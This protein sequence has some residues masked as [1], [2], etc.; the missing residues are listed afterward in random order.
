MNLRTLALA[1]ALVASPLSAQQW[2][3]FYTP[4]SPS[5]RCQPC[6][7]E[8]QR[9]I[10]AKGSDSAENVQDAIELNEER[11]LNAQTDEERETYKSVIELVKRDVID[12]TVFADVDAKA[13]RV[14]HDRPYIF[15][16]LIDEFKDNLSSRLYVDEEGLICNITIPVEGV[17]NVGISYAE[18]EHSRLLH[19]RVDGM[20]DEEYFT[21]Q[22]YDDGAMNILSDAYVGIGETSEDARSKF[23]ANLKS[24]NRDLSF[25]N[26]ELFNKVLAALDERYT[27][28]RV[29]EQEELKQL[30]IAERQL[31]RFSGMATMTSR[32][33]AAAVMGSLADVI[34]ESIPAI[35]S[36]NEDPL[37]LH[38]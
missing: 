7:Q 35:Q 13:K 10:F 14:L 37:G 38:R 8:N 27:A 5:R 2:S 22:F 33:D 18:R 26:T 31:N 12:D 17:E 4:P 25:E 20:R 30:E 28:R 1:A 3:W 15:D 36:Y 9:N 24:G 19:M 11:L 21:A 34:G 29:E 32:L 16:K 6:V 23:V